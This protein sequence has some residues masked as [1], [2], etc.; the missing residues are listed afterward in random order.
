MSSHVKKQEFPLL[1]EPNAR[2]EWSHLEPFIP[3]NHPIRCWLPTDDSPT[4]SLGGPCM[5]WCWE[6]RTDGK[7][8]L[9]LGNH[10]WGRAIAAPKFSLRL[11]AFEN[12]IVPW[13]SVWWELGV[14]L[15]ISIPSHRS[16]ISAF[17]STADTLGG[18]GLNWFCKSV[19][20][21]MR[22]WVWVSEPQLCCC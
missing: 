8:S 3:A 10:V 5:S 20:R 15:H 13:F 18:R 4:N 1:P 22:G 2:H 17:T 11:E 19:N 21:V 7:W 16:P 6:L 9:F 12:H 14:L